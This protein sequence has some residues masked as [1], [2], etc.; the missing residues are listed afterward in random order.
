VHRCH[1]L[2]A[3]GDA[4][5]ARA[6][7]GEVAYLRRRVGAKIRGNKEEGRNREGR[8]EWMQRRERGREGERRKRRDYRE[9]REETRTG[10]G[11]SPRS[12]AKS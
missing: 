1:A 5:A 11:E 10:E 6:S 8:N 2:Q 3:P 12:R 7:L 9:R 4:D